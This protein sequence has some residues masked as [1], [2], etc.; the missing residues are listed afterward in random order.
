[1]LRLKASIIGVLIKESGHWYSVKIGK[2]A[3]LW[4]RRSNNA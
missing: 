2:G 3:R 1:M 4:L